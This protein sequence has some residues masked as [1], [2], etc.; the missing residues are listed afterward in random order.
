M[1]KVL[2]AR[3]TGRAAKFLQML[4]DFGHLDE[5]SG[6]EVFMA[7]ADHGASR[8]E[9]IVDLPVVRRIAAAVLFGDAFEAA[10]ERLDPTLLA[11]DW[12]L[13]FS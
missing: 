5:E 1:E 6:H 8:R 12:P 11:E 3:L 4:Q 9:M 13:L 2:K 7:I 10:S